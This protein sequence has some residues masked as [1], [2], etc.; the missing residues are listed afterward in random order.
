MRR[1]IFIWQD[2]YIIANSTMF[3]N[4]KIWFEDELVSQVQGLKSHNAVDNGFGW[5]AAL[6]EI[7]YYSTLHHLKTGVRY[8]EYNRHD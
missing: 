8:N 2:N 1:Y 7:L 3:Y 4:F 5:I 6:Y